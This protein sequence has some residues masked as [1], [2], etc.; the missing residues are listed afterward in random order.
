M[1]D[2]H[3]VLQSV[4]LQRGSI[5]RYICQDVG[6]LWLSPCCSCLVMALLLKCRASD[7]NRVGLVS[8]ELFSFNMRI[9]EDNS[10]PA[11]KFIAYN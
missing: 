6:S 3:E 7:L 5:L 2:F 11:S 10:D 4:G 9:F 8:R 1:N